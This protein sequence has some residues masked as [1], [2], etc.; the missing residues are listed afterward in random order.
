MAGGRGEGEL[1]KIKSVRSGVVGANGMGGERELF[2]VRGRSG[3]ESELDFGVAASSLPAGFDGAGGERGEMKIGERVRVG[4]E[5][6][7]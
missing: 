6:K 3:V 7:G 2:G 4:V 1:R 5:C